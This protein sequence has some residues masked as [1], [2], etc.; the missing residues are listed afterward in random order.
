MIQFIWAMTILFSVQA[1]SDAPPSK[2]VQNMIE[3]EINMQPPTP[4][5]I[6]SVNKAEYFYVPKGPCSCEV[7]RKYVCVKDL[8]KRLKQEVE[9]KQKATQVECNP[10]AGC[11]PGTA[12]IYISCLQPGR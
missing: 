3:K 6:Y 9:K 12:W 10:A 4:Y 2:K 1:F 7:D 11:L 8:K 5:E